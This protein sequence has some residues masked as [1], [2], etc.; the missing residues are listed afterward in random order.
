MEQ[1]LDLK[2]KSII[3]KLRADRNF[4]HSPDTRLLKLLGDSLG[5][6]EFDRILQDKEILS[7]LPNRNLII[8]PFYV[9][10]F[11]QE[12]IKNESKKSIYDPWLTIT[13]PILYI[14]EE[15]LN[16]TCINKTDLDTIKAIFKDKSSNFKTGNNLKVLSISNE[17]FDIVLSFPPFGLRTESINGSKSP[18]DLGATLLLESGEKIEDNGKLIFLVSNSF[19]MNERSKKALKEKEL[20]VDAVFALPAGTFA[21]TTNISTSIIVISKKVNEKTF[22]AEISKE[23][24]INNVILQNF[25]TQKEGKTN[26]L[27]SFVDLNE[28]KSFNALLAEKEMQE[29]G[30]RIGYLPSSLTEISIS[31]NV[32]KSNNLEE[33]EHLPNSIYLPKIGNSQAFSSLSELKIKP[34]NYHQIQLDETKAN[35]IYIANYFNTSVGKKLRRSLETGGYIPQISKTELLKCLLFIPDFNTQS[36]IVEVDIKIQQLAIKLEELNRNLWNQPRKYQSINKEVK[37]INNEENLENWIDKLPFPI[38]SILWLYYATIE[39]DKKIEHLFNF[40]E[41]FSEF[42]SMLILSALINDKEFYTRESYR[43]TK[44]PAHFK[45]WYLRT[46]FGS[47]NMLLADLS[48]SVRVFLGNKE[49]HDLCLG[50][51]SHPSIEFLE[52]IQSSKIF[53]ILDEVRVLR[54]NWKGHTGITPRNIQSRVDTLEQH[55]NHLRR[56]IGDGFESVSILSSAKDAHFED[57]IGTY[58]A[59]NL[60]G[61]KSPFRQVKVQTTMMLDRKKLYLKTSESSDPIELL[62][63]IK[64]NE[65]YEAIYFYSKIESMDVRWI[66]Y[67]FDKEADIKRPIGIELSKAFD[68]LKSQSN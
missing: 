34:K 35:S 5:D 4:S 1:D 50:L 49:T 7:N 61:A 38:S 52:I 13:S 23:N 9:L 65:E 54:N 42:M 46:D 66:S 64:Y 55:L 45:E 43:W 24:T 26:Q 28:F 37:T 8:S 62:P 44:K 36:E 39:K 60:V 12:L 20:F 22:V 48:K 27:G 30:K 41:A 17:K 63:F 31:I 68:F 18:F 58:T 67:H 56:E 11:I 14:E 29:L 51:F 33:I 59:R 2:I 6:E 19:L 15:T 57:G 3:D 32:L 21:P 10:D 25:K 47:W 53:N 16:G 40:F